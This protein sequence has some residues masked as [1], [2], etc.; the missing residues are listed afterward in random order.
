M[1]NFNSCQKILTYQESLM[2][3]LEENHPIFCELMLSRIFPIRTSYYIILPTEE[4]L[5][6]LKLVNFDID[7]KKVYR[8]SFYEWIFPQ[9]ILMTSP[10]QNYNQKYKQE[11]QL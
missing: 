9:S 6:Q 10:Y 2:Y 11:Q 3:Y 5:K 7:V 1:N 4:S 8:L